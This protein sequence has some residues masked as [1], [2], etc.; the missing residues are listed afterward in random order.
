MATLRNWLAK[1]SPS[2]ADLVEL[3]SARIAEDDFCVQLEL[4][5]TAKGQNYV[6]VMSDPKALLVNELDGSVSYRAKV[7]AVTEGRDSGSVAEGRKFLEEHGCPAKQIQVLIK[8]MNEALERGT[9]KNFPKARRVVDFFH[10]V[11]LLGKA[12]TKIRR[13]ESWKIPNCS[14]VAFGLYVRMRNI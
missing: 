10:V 13:Q 1:A 7:I 8:D 9:K 2:N 5:D 11:A 3:P 4:S 12:F 6:T 14:R